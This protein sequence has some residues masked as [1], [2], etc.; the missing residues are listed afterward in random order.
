MY[1]LGR[2]GR[3]GKKQK[4]NW[5]QVLGPHKLLEKFDKTYLVDFVHSTGSVTRKQQ[6][7]SRAAWRGARAPNGTPDEHGTVGRRAHKTNEAFGRSF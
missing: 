1:I 7:A 3:C 5:A 2:T 4:I 6:P